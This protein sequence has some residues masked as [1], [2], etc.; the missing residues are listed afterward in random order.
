MR[1]L[2]VIPVP[3][4]M[5]AEQAFEEII[6]MGQLVDRVVSEDGEGGQWVTVSCEGDCGQ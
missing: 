6:V 5:T 1:H 4:G 2:H 3:D